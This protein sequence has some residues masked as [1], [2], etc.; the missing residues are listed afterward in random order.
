MIKQ[1][2]MILAEHVVCM[3]EMGNALKIVVW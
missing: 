3:V 1:M 2:G